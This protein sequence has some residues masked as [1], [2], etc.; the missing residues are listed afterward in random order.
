M[1]RLIII[2]PLALVAACSG[3]AGD[4]GGKKEEPVALVRTVAAGVGSA[5]AQAPVYGMVEPGAGGEMSLV[6]PA[7]AV[8]ERILAPNGTPVAAG[9]PI[10]TLR[11]SR[12]AA[13]D[14]AK[15][16]ADAA[17][18]AAAYARAQRMRGEGLVSD[19]DVETARA[20]Q[21]GAQAALA[22]LGMGPGGLTLRAR[23]GG[24]VQKLTARGGDQ[25][26][27]GTALASVASGHDLQIRFGVD[28]ALA[29]RIHPGLPLVLATPH[30]SLTVSG[31]DSQPDPATRQTSLYARLPKGLA[32]APG[33]AV[34][35][36]LELESAARRAVSVPY[37]ALLDD[38]GKS[39]VFVVR[40]GVAHRQDVLPG[41]S[42]GEAIDILRG[43]SP[44]DRLVVEGASGLDD[45][46]K[47]R[48]Q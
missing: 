33:Q 32:L 10:L 27:A 37:G 11:P 45:G 48:E 35:A 6:A 22:R 14:L 15:A 3:G 1:K 29:R 8:V 13:G 47:V 42:S 26:A 31:V 5:S 41:N 20:A 38:G 23:H 4:E 9:T 39:Y 2:A 19:A 34:S 25:V 36:V 7:E 21:Q 46:M 24:V 28:P 44:G 16:A 18:S 40:G 12:A 43:V 17:A 30:A